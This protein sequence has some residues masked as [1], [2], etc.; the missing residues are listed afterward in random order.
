MKYN[1]TK[2]KDLSL[3]NDVKISYNF[4][5]K[6]YFIIFNKKQPFTEF[7][8]YQTE[9]FEKKGFADTSD[10]IIFI[11]LLD[12]NNEIINLDNNVLDLIL[13]II[14][15][16]SGPKGNFYKDKNLYINKES[17]YLLKKYI[18]TSIYEICDDKIDKIK[19]L[20]SDGSEYNI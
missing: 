20:Y 4:S 1:P 8:I 12:A 7:P 10:N 6:K 11:E 16:Y 18:F 5:Y 2:L 17:I 15:E 9:E 19:I 13:L 3:E 14:K